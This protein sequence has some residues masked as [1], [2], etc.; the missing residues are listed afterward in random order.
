MRLILRRTQDMT[1]EEFEDTPFGVDL[2]VVISTDPDLH[3][4]LE[5]LIAEAEDPERFMEEVLK[6][7]ERWMSR[8][9]KEALAA[10]AYGEISPAELP[11]Y[12]DVSPKEL[13]DYSEMS[14]PEY[15]AHERI[16]EGPGCEAEA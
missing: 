15:S 11:G 6:F 7:I 14:P 3:S 5:K 9:G 2:A 13:S 4:L 12:S 1:V 8:A 16:V 10:L